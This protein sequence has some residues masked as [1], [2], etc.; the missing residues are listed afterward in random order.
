MNGMLSRAR[1]LWRG[2]RRPD[3]LEAEMDEEMRFHV[4]MEAER[5]MRERGLGPAEARRRAALAFGGTEKYKEEGRDARGLTRLSGM[6]LDFRLGIRMLAR[7]PGLTVVGGAAMAFGIAVGTGSFH[8]LKEM[9][10]PPLPYADAGRIVY[11]RNVSTETTLGDDRALHDFA[12]W[13]AEL[14]S[15]DHLSAIHERERNLS[16][17]SG[18]AVPV[19][20]AAVSAAAFDL[21][22]RPLLGR[23]L[24]PADEAPGAPAVAV[25]AHEL[26]RT[27]F[28][29]DPGAV[30]R[31]VRVGGER[32]TIVGVMPEDFA[33]FVPRAG[34]TTPAPQHLW[35]PFRLDPLHHA[36]GKGP[37]VTVFGRLAPGATLDEARA[38]LA[39]LGARAAK[40]SP[41]THA[42]LT[43]RV[44]AFA[45][46]PWSG[47]GLALHGIFAASG[48]ALAALMAVLC[49]NVALLL[50]ARAATREAEIAVRS[51]L[52]ASRGRIVFQLFAEALVLAGAAVVVGLAGA[53]AGVAWVIRVLGRL[54]EAQGVTLPPWVDATLSPATVGAA[55]A[56]TLVGAVVAGVLPGLGVT[57]R[58][59]HGRLQQLAGR[60]AGT[61]MG[62]VWTGI[63]VTQVALTVMFVPVAAFLGLRAWE[64]R[65]TETGLPGAG[66]LSVWIYMA[67]EAPSAA[68]GAGDARSMAGFVEG[69]RA[70][71][72]RLA[73]EPGVT[74]VTVAERLPGI[75]HPARV[76]EVEASGA[77][78]PATEETH[79]Q[80][81]SVDPDFFEV[82]GAPILSGRGLSAADVGHPVVVVNESFVRVFLGGRDALGRRLRYRPPAGDEEAEPTPWHE[83]VGVSRD[84]A[85]TVDPSLPH[86]SGVY[87]PLR[88]GESDAVQMAV[89]VEGGAGGF[90]GRLLEIGADEPALR[91]GR[92]RPI[93]HAARGMVIAYDAWFRVVVLA[94]AMAVLLTNAGIYAVISFTVSR[95]TREIGVRV[96]L[97]ADRR[98]I[99]AAILSRIARQV[100]AGVLVGAVL[101][102]FLAFALAEGSWRPSVLG[103][104]GLLAAYMA[105]MM[106]VCMLACIV[107][108]RRALR[109]EPMEALSADG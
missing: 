56:L 80:L 65:N 89:R 48:L 7:Y 75:P 91:L 62:R 93:D 86:H 105:V 5:L 46:T 58:G 15:V 59:A 77:P 43:P 23:P 37:A 94:G 38:E 81:G 69:Y 9:M 50:Y 63:V 72:R 51:A 61:R 108:T 87:H 78:L 8:L 13:R 32:T 29:G 98:R 68:G 54:M 82:M 99:V 107:P 28:G 25:I 17:A 11:I 2:L 83:I 42:R 55:V 44:R 70:L 90:G 47:G 33:F 40:A 20:E 64:M 73:A 104:G 10:L 101:G 71:E 84:M 6:S 109:I 95:R 79:T 106:G 52:G 39:T 22:P 96:A 24:V 92:P 35:V 4:E 19:S 102:V 88:P 53:S 18:P 74:G 3:R 49:G 27:R 60:G 67:G 76:V 12:A 45:R 1:S 34:F 21:V 85:M 103:G 14:R 66:V 36:P 26:W 31:T 97:G 100:G 16:L 30:G 57:G 41:A